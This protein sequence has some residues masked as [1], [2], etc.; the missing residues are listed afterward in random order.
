MVGHRGRTGLSEFLLGS[1][2]N[3]VMHHAPCSVL[4]VN[5]PKADLASETEAADVATPV[6]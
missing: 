6:T 1:V 5:N 2:S 4:V 3:Y